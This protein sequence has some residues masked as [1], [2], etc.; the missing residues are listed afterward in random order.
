M[1]K[2]LEAQKHLQKHYLPLEEKNPSYTVQ[3][4]PQKVI[5]KTYF[6]LKCYNLKRLTLDIESVYLWS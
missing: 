3:F 1:H 4:L 2:I 6:S 5:F